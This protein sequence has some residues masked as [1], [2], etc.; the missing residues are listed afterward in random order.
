MDKNILE[1]ADMTAEGYN[2][3]IFFKS[4]RVASLCYTG[5]LF[6][7]QI[8][9]LERHNQTDEIFILVRGQATLMM[10]GNGGSVEKVEVVPMQPLK[11]YN[12]RQ[13][14]WHSVIVS[15]DVVILLVEAAD[16][17]RSNSE[18]FDLTPS[19]KQVY[20][21]VAAKYPDWQAVISALNSD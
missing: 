18:Y 1:V 11:T 9:F 10:G 14:A 12:V 6:P 13:S 20:L 21:S 3:L 17:D 2:P 7:P 19:M 15:K 16:T 4:W 5:D 8:G